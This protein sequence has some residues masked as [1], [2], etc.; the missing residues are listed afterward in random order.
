MEQ[1]YTIILPSKKLKLGSSVRDR[2]MIFLLETITSMISSFST[3]EAEAKLIEQMPDRR[4]AIEKLK[5]YKQLHDAI[6]EKLY[7]AHV[8]H[9]RKLFE[10]IAFQTLLDHSNAAFMIPEALNGLLDVFSND[11]GHVVGKG[12]IVANLLFHDTL[13]HPNGQF[14]LTFL[15]KG[16]HVKD[17]R[18]C[19]AVRL[20]HPKTS[21]NWR[22]EPVM[23]FIRDELGVNDGCDFGNTFFKN[24]AGAE[25]KLL[26]RYRT[27]DLLYA[28]KSF[29]NDLHDLVKRSGLLGDAAGMLWL[30]LND[31]GKPYFKLS[32][33]DN[34]FFYSVSAD[35][36]K[37][38]DV[39][40]RFVNMIMHRSKQDEAFQQRMIEK[41][42]RK[43]Q[44]EKM[45]EEKEIEKH[46]QRVAAQKQRMRAR[47]QRRAIKESERTR[48]VEERMT[49]KLSEAHV[50]QEHMAACSSYKELASITGVSVETARKRVKKASMLLGV[51]LSLSGKRVEDNA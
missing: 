14:D 32:T 18:N 24:N 3:N 9:G 15:G 25:K 31:E 17:R 38:S 33:M 1:L 7:E 34:V 39:R 42:E 37:V 6:I 11:P 26:A 22:D 35:G 49:R 2:F 12:E 10:S 20:G 19:E 43:K 8:M 23:K 29:E 51:K 13:G 46:M 27:T 48:V 47:E 4:S 41:Q 45:R 36:I 50:L 5:N 16:Y 30:K 44:K 28:A 40:D 21:T